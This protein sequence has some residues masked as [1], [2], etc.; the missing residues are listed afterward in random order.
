M[1]HLHAHSTYSFLD[2]Y[3]TPTQIASRIAELGHDSVAVTDHGNVFAHVPYAKAMKKMGI[4][5]IY[6]CEFYIVD[7]MTARE[8][9]QSSLGVDAFP[10]VT[11]LA[12][13]SM[14]YGNLLRLSRKSW[15]DGFYRLPRIDWNAL[16]AHQGGLVILSGCIGGYPSRLIEM[17]GYDAAASF[18]YKISQRIEKFYMELNP[19][20]GAA[21]S[22]ATADMVAL[23][24]SELSIPLVLTADA[25][26]PRPCDH[27]AQQIM[28]C[29]GMRK[30]MSDDIGISIPAYQYYCDEEDLLKRAQ[31][32]CTDT[33]ISWLKQASINTDI[34]AAMCNVE[35]PKASPVV[36]PSVPVG[37]CPEN[38]LW[39]MVEA[40]IA[41]RRSRGHIPEDR[42]EEY[43]ERAKSEW[44]VL[45]CK[46]FADYVLVVYDIVKYAKQRGLLAMCRGSAGGCLVLWLLGAS[47]TDSVK[48]GLSFERFYDD[49]RDD[50]PDVDLDF[51]RGKRDEIISYVFEKYG[52]EN[53]SQITALSQLK[54]KAALQDT[55]F[56]LGIP[57]S[58]YVRLS[59]AI[60]ST[61]ED[62]DSQIESINDPE[63]LAVLVK[64]PQL[65]MFEQLIGQCRQSSVNAAGVLISSQRLA[66]MVGIVVGRDG[67]PVAAV[68]K[69]GAQ[70]LGFLKLD[71]L[72][73]NSL[74]IIGYALRRLGDDVSWI[75]DIPLDDPKVYATARAGRLAG[76]FQLDGASAA[77][78]MRDIGADRF[79]DLV[80]AGALCRP[81]PSN[82]VQTYRLHKGSQQAFARFMSGI[83]PAARAVV[84][85]T[86]GIVIY[87]E[88]LMRL[89]RDVAGFTWADVHALRRAIHDKDK[90]GAEWH[91]K[92]ILGCQSFGGLSATE[93]E[94]W[95]KQIRDHGGY[96][97]NRSHGTTYAI[98]GYWMLYL[99]TYHPEQFYEAYLRL[100]DSPWTRKR[101]VREFIQIGGSVSLL[102][103][104]SGADLKSIGGM[105]LV[106]GLTGI[107]G[108][109]GKTAEKIAE[110][111]PFSTFDDMIA[112]L[113]KAPRE[114]I[115]GARLADGR[116]DPQRTI[117]I[118][119]WFP[120]TCTS[121]SDDTQRLKRGFVKPGAIPR[122]GTTG[123]VAV[124]GY[125]S[126]TDV[127][128][129]RIAVVVE[130]E[131]G[132]VL[133]KASARDV[134]RMLKPFQ[135]VQ[136]GDY[137]AVSGWW[138]GDSLM[139]KAVEILRR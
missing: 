25:H 65:R 124:S 47:E 9:H 136:L 37:R 10:H 43:T 114:A 139:A 66:D 106:G 86:Y 11:V 96:S 113:P 89:C 94:F 127:S 27:E 125:A 45:C 122:D 118:A 104:S 103:A 90:F 78:V 76:V 133:V 51:E 100:D 35:I 13:N 41:N 54:A 59:N 7:D 81:G 97:F 117:R 52:Q 98:I 58:D 57:R 72:S 36:Y 126:D 24:A 40:G 102:D 20:P 75:Y 110:R 67:T 132:A 120:V 5:P 31:D 138:N 82:M 44:R 77:R 33:P 68:D 116:W 3:G 30:R 17:H 55:A 23:I 121:P 112:A 32:V 49:T 83:S 128:D 16:V 42:L 73:V 70:D 34:I 111:G 115:I 71:M 69:R 134:R 79:D 91:D 62:I 64:Y 99:K 108:I 28:L 19:A 93:S 12:E 84:E 107:K 88:Q 4:K 129:K 53:C 61:D 92:F 2:G 131:T 101:L 6:G 119:S 74:D 48:H 130:D 22:H 39:S 60:E 46:G 123:E 38:W 8:K 87:Q 29:A 80:A 50:P 26:F 56:V 63:A 21:T 105:R 109:A 135:E 1:R 85:D 18:V 15:E 14:G 137:I 95:W